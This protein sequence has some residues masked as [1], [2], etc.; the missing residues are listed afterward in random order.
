M[1]TSDHGISAAEA[2][3]LLSGRV[4]AGRD[5]LAPIGADLAS[6]SAAYVQE[7]DPAVVRQWAAMAAGHTHLA[8]SDNG[9]LAAT[10]ASDAYRPALQ[11]SGPPKRR[12]PVLKS[13]LAYL[14][15]T[16]GKVSQTSPIAWSLST[17]LPT[18]PTG[19]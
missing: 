11:A 2:D 7:V 6:L 4:P 12:T 9:D 15:T 16:A 5:D 17:R 1:G 19:T 14:S 10:P 8:P 18:R 13:I 3:Q